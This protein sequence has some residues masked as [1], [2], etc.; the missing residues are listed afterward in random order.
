M[1]HNAAAQK[2][3]QERRMP[4]KRI[5]R[6]CIDRVVPKNLL[7]EELR[8]NEA[9]LEE[10]A[11]AVNKHTDPEIT[12]RPFAHRAFHV[13]SSAMLDANHPIH[14]ARMAVINSRKWDKGY[15]LR[16]RFLDGS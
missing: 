4:T 11:A 15:K 10:Y 13:Q 8:A 3:Q 16:C 7:T 9:A 12:G 2:G 1:H 14:R 5:P 6:T